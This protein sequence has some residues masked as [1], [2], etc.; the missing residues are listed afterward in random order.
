MSNY[1]ND[2]LAYL[3]EALEFFKKLPDFDN[4][5]QSLTTPNRLIEVNFPILLDNGRKILV[6]GF[7]SQFNNLLGPYKGGI[8]FHKNATAQEVTNLSFL[9]T[10]KN[11][12]VNLPFGGGKG[13]VLVDPKKFSKTELERISRGYTEAIVDC[14]GPRID[15]PAP[16]VNTNS[17]IM[18]W[19]TDEYIK[20]K[21]KKE[22][23]KNN[24]LLATF[25]GKSLNNGGV[26]GREEATGLGGAIILQGMLAKLKNKFQYKNEKPTVAIQGFGNVG[27][28]LAKYLYLS[29]F[30]IVAV[31]DSKGAIYVSEGLNPDLTLQC[32]REKG[33]LSGCYCV[34]SV[35]D[36]KKGRRITNSK[37]LSLPVDILVPAALE[38]SINRDNVGE[39]DASIILE[40][41]NAPLSKEADK[42]LSKRGVV[43]IPDILANSGGVTVSYF[44]WRQ[45]LDNK[46][47]TID[48][49]RR[50]IRQKLEEA[51]ENVWQIK[52]KYRVNLRIASYILALERFKQ[53]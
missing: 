23:L 37:M 35:C 3:D 24:E 49:V 39:I 53:K 16:D 4:F 34:G 48:Q 38:N 10:I 12:V 13:G 31:S 15:V 5:R 50:K 21:I 11:A 9:M 51:V 27:Y 1:F 25:T 47:L 44:E 33:E 29:G 46:T 6:K 22:K 20:L 45:N 40:M 43:I 42:I 26:V 19:M 17:V 30:K 36:L 8:R 28:F 2:S 7:R 14:I 41:A 32:K 52:Q 18:D